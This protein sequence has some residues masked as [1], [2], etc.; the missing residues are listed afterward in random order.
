MRRP[1]TYAAAVLVAV[2]TVAGC[3]GSSPHTASTTTPAA[4]AATPSSSA[5]VAPAGATTV[6]ISNYAYGPPALTVKAGTKVTFVNHDATA[7]TAT[8]SSTPGFDTG[9]IKPNS[10]ATVT[11]TKPGTYSYICQFHPFMKATI[12]VG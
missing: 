12:T 10:R 11:L 4:P 1:P 3:G 7:H 5:S 8:A 2:L 6:N 9:S